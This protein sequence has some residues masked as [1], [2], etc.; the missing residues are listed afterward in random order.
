MPYKD[1][2][3]VMMRLKIIFLKN[4]GCSMENELQGGKSGHRET[5]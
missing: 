3:K 4:V 5:N 1:V 2:N